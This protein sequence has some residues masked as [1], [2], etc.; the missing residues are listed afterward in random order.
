MFNR[1][2]GIMAEVPYWDRYFK[3]TDDS[4]NIAGYNH[5]SIGDVRLKGIYS[6]FSSDMS[7]GITFGLKLPTG[8]FSYPNFD[9][10]TEIGSGSTDVL[11]GA[12]HLGRLSEDGS[13]NWFVNGELDQPVL[14][15]GGYRPGSE[16]DATGG[17][18]YEKWSVGGVKITP[19]A[20]MLGSYRLS[21]RG[22][23]ADPEDSGY[24]RAL[25]APGIE[26]SKGSWRLFG[27][28]ALPVYQ[29][30]TGNQLT[31]PALFKISLSYDF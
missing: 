29:N 27:D 7:G 23:Q 3:T 1:D 9:R 31:A 11:L 5:D 18:Y 22:Q 17:V 4:G 15:S 16:V 14:I 25:F 26:A 24:K 8:D 20:Q 12:Y 19:V 28:V 21:D 6:G 2:W 13:W 30:V 10:D